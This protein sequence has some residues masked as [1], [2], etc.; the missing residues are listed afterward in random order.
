M[1]SFS[2]V[3][4]AWHLKFQWSVLKQNLMHSL[5]SEFLGFLVL[6]NFKLGCRPL[7]KLITRI[8][9]SSSLQNCRKYFLLFFLQC[10]LFY[11]MFPFDIRARGV[12]FL[13]RE[14]CLESQLI[15]NKTKNSK[16]LLDCIWWQARII[17]YF[18]CIYA[19]IYV[20]HIHIHYRW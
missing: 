4:N 17:T 18:Y 20:T 10:N 1:L 9:Y 14:S 7:G 11:L 16:Y 2:W 8:F 5:C 3:S 12:K 19:H 6:S 13:V 15:S